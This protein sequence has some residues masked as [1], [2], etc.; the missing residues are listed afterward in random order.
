MFLFKVVE[1]I[2]MATA[3]FIV[4]FTLVPSGLGLPFSF[5]LGWI[6]GTVSAK[7]VL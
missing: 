1:I 6:V 5:S 3:M 2:L 7:L 4:V